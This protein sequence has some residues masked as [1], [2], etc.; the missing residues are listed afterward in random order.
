M[1]SC[2]CQLH[3]RALRAREPFSSC[4]WVYDSVLFGCPHGSNFLCSRVSDSTVSLQRFNFSGAL[5]LRTRDCL[6]VSLSLYPQ[7]QFFFKLTNAVLFYFFSFS[8]ALAMLSP[9]SNFLRAHASRFRSNNYVY[10][11]VATVPTY[12]RSCLILFD[13]V[14]TTGPN[15]LRAR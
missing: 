4:S 7:V 2:V 6:F 8:F 15:F 3:S 9:M 1:G 11:V 5:T 13:F 12:P 10:F 14:V